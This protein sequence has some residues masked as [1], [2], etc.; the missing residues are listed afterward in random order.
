MVTLKNE[1]SKSQYMK[2]Y[3]VAGGKEGKTTFLV[4]SLLGAL[5]HQKQGLV[6]SP[7]H[8]HLL[9]IDSNAVG[10]LAQFLTKV[11]GKSEDYLEV[12]VHNMQDAAN[13][14]SA[15]RTDWDFSFFNAMMMK[16]KDIRAQIAKVP[17]VHAVVCSSLTGLAEALQRGMSG[18]P[19]PS[20]K[21]GGMDIAKWSDLTR[22][23]VELRNLLQVDTHHMFWEGHVFKA[24]GGGQG[25]AEA[26][27]EA[28][29]PGKVGKNWGFNV[30]QVFRLRREL[31]VCYP[32]TL[33][34]KQ[35]LDT[36]P[37]LDFTSGG[38]GFTGVLEAKEYDLVDVAVKLGYKVGAFGAK[39]T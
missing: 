17:G 19:D 13:L 35:Y 2:S 6:T 34:E 11:C 28:G 32:N 23:L 1:T 39:T 24:G 21:G 22:Q 5:P 18:P 7:A 26:H 16:V 14:V 33:V 10:G 8:L 38:R 25:G 27:E 29:V 9:G 31:R 3:V 37:T 12:D 36:K 20:K 30:D 4:A 15:S